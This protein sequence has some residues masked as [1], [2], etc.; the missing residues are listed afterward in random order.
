MRVCK[1]LNQR[2]RRIGEKS[3]ESFEG[4]FKKNKKTLIWRDWVSWLIQDWVF[5]TV[6]GCRKV[7]GRVPAVLRFVLL[8]YYR[9]IIIDVIQTKF[10]SNQ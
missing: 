8:P 2:V 10:P 4:F 6:S 9:G 1:Y 7:L 3:G 5:T